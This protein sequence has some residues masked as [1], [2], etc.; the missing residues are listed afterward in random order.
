MGCIQL[1]RAEFQQLKVGSVDSHSLLPE[2][3][4]G[5]EPVFDFDCHHDNQK[6]RRQK[7]QS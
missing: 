2:N 3:H 5:P 4:R 1:H 7:D 6:N